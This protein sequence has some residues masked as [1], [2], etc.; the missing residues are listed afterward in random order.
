MNKC[1]IW[2]LS[3]TPRCSPSLILSVCISLRVFLLRVCIMAFCAVRRVEA[4]RSC[5]ATTDITGLQIRNW[6]S[7]PTD[8]RP[9]SLVMT[10]WQ[11]KLWKSQNTWFVKRWVFKCNWTKKNYLFHCTLHGGT[12]K[13]LVRRSTFCHWSMKGRTR[14]TPGPLGGRIRPRRKTTILS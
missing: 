5:T 9:P 8:T 3:L 14:T 12:L 11:G 2:Y 7:A 10:F 13:A 6:I 1:N 4:F